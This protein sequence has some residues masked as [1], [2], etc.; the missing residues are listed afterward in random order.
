M[1]AVRDGTVR[2][3]VY[4]GVVTMSGKLDR[5]SAVDV[6][7]RLAARVGG[8]VEVINELG[9]DFDDSELPGFPSFP[10]QPIRVS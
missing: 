3:E 4:G 6:A 5:R 9:Y 2:V 10:V 7:G 8:V 1:L